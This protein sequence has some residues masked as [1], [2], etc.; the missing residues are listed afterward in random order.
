MTN[1]CFK[2][3][4]NK[5]L[6]STVFVRLNKLKRDEGIVNMMKRQKTGIQIMT[7]KTTKNK[8]LNTVMK[9]KIQWYV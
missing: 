5:R 3:T 2:F 7:M 8:K 4:T 9:K 6:Q 1:L